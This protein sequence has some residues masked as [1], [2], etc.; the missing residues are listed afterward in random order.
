LSEGRRRLEAVLAVGEN[1]P[2]AL[3]ARVLNGAGRLAIRQGEYA[4]AQAMLEESLDRWRSLGDTKGEMQALNSLGLVAIFQNDLPRAQSLFEESIVGWRALGDKHGMSGGQNNLGLALRYQGEFERAAEAYEGSLA[5][6]RELGN[7][8]MMSAATHNL[9]QMAHHQGDDAR[10]HRLL[11]ESLLLARQLNDRANISVYLADLAG[12]WAAHEEE[13]ERAARLFGASEALRESMG[14]IMYRA[15]R[16]VFEQDA[17]GVKARLG[18]AA[19]N[20]AYAEGRAL[21]L[22]D[23]FALAIEEL[24]QPTPAEARAPAATQSAYNLT[25]REIEVLRQLADGLTYAEIAEQ[26]TLSFHTVH[27]HMRSIY[28]KL[29]VSSRGQAARFAKEHGLA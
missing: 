3:R 8:Y 6:A 22:E 9:G 10:A 20:A 19:W 27:A 17:E 14:V 12:V 28:G 15:Q 1:L 7:T 18:A 24:P 16:S 13:Q 2:A 4:Q 29:G 5:L 26:L 11:V 23:A 25:E 21:T